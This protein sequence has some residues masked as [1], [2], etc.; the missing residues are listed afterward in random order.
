VWDHVQVDGLLLVADVMARV[1]ERRAGE[2]LAN[3]PADLVTMCDSGAYRLLSQGTKLNPENIL[4][5]QR[6]CGAPLNVQ[7]DWPITARSPLREIELHRRRTLETAR[8]WLEEFGPD[9]T[10]VVVH[11]RNASELDAALAGLCNLERDFGELKHLA[12]GSVARISRTSPLRVAEL[13]AHC[14][15]HRPHAN[16]HIFGVGATTAVL[17]A[18]IGIHSVDSSSHIMDASFGLARHPI[19]LA[20]HKVAGSN[21]DECDIPNVCNCP[22]CRNSPGDLARPGREGVGARA[23]HNIWLL[24]RM[25]RE[26]RVPARYVRALSTVQAWRGQSTLDD[27][28]GLGGV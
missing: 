21:S 23:I 15:R 3:I 18:T 17:L 27:V 11:G 28:L 13:A 5:I 12:L 19:T 10:V 9:H 22:V 16:W 25:V 2:F 4:A 14:L 20:P 8:L 26:R 24:Q 7:L 6:S 1:G